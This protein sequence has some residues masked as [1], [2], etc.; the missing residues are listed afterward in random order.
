MRIIVKLTS[1]EENEAV[2]IKNC[3]HYV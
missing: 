3:H 2:S 1:G